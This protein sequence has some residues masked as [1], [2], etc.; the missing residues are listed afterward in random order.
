MVSLK[1]NSINYAKY[2]NSCDINYKYFLQ[3]IKD[4]PVLDKI[5][6]E[7]PTNKLPN[8]EVTEDDYQT[9]LLLKCFLVSYFI[10]FK[11]PY[12]NCNKFKNTDIT[13]GT[14]SSYHYAYLQTNNKIMDKYQ[15]MLLL[16]NEN[17]R[18]NISIK[19][20]TKLNNKLNI[21]K[22]QKDILNFRLEVQASRIVEYREVLNTFFNRGE[23]QNLK[24]K[25]NFIFK[26]FNTKMISVNEFRNFFFIWNI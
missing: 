11:M 10:N 14:N 18:S 13:L 5:V 6:F 12:I 1:Y 2:L 7:L 3:S 17:D 16:L 24:F 9:R 20:L 25:F 4:T 26:N 8:V 22:Y 21:N 19:N 15:L 23:L